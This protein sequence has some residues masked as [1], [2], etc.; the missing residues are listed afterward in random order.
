M[1]PADFYR[2][3]AARCR[4]RAERSSTTERAQKWAARAEQYLRLASELDSAAR[5]L[6]DPL[7][8][9]RLRRTSGASVLEHDEAA[10]AGGLGAN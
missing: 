8:A 7:P 2:G 9:R 3:E 6:G 1:T 4:Q 5:P 10:N